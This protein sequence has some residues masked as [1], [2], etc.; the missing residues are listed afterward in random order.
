MSSPCRPPCGLGGASECAPPESSPR[1]RKASGGDIAP[2]GATSC[3]LLG[4]GEHRRE[5]KGCC[6]VTWSAVCKARC[7]CS[8]QVG[9]SEC[10]SSRVFMNTYARRCQLLSLL[11]RSMV[12]VVV[13]GRGAVRGGELPLRNRSGLINLCV[14][15]RAGILAALIPGTSHDWHLG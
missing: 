14:I 13:R 12:V 6:L 5:G 8:P 7:C 3:R 10:T 1:E 15:L 11:Q 4:E 9:G 2:L